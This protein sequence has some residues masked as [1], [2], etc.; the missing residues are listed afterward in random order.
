MKMDTA[1]LVLEIADCE[2]RRN[3]AEQERDRLRGKLTFLVGVIEGWSARSGIP[4][5]LRDDMRATLADM[6]GGLKR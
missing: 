3:V 4:D 1:Q 6:M 2:V 5:D